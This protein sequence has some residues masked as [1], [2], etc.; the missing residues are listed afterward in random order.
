MTCYFAKIIW[1]LIKFVYGIDFFVVCMDF[2]SLNIVLADQ[3]ITRC[4]L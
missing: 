1:Q 4:A 2:V 3:M